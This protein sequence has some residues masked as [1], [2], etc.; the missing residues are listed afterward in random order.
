MVRLIAF[1]ILVGLL[2]AGAVWLA[3][4]PGDVTVEW[5]GWRV[6]TTVPVLLLALALL[7]AVFAAIRAAVLALL[8]VPGFFGRKRRD[9]RQRKGMDALAEGLAAVIAEDVYRARKKAAEAES[10]L[11]LPQVARLL[12]ARA[13]LLGDDP[14]VARDLNREL[15][16]NRGTEMA[17]LRGLMDEALSE[18]RFEEAAGY[19]AR[20]FDRNP[21]AAWAGRAL[22]EAQVKGRQW[23]AA[24][25]T[26][27]TARK[28][29]VFP[30]AEA[31]RLRATIFCARHDEAAAAG[32]KYEATRF[33][34]KAVDAEPAF[35]P[36]Q[37]RLARSLAAEGSTRK[38]ADLIEQAWRRSPNPE[39]ARAYMDL[40]RDEDVLKRVTRAERLAETNPEHLE[41]RLL[42]AQASLE[43]ELW[44]QARA[45]LKPAVDGGVRDARLAALMARLEEA[46]RG[47]LPEAV[48]W[49]RQAAEAAGLEPQPWRCTACGTATSEWTPTCGA[50]GS[51]GRVAWGGGRALVT[52]HAPDAV[53]APPTRPGAPATGS[54]GERAATEGAAASPRAAAGAA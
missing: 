1:L 46:E 32:Q 21:R 2:V 50:C 13:A 39:L 19:A 6:D 53:P 4:R 47:N 34:R 17:G 37:I 24:L 29:G 38:A 18:G 44:G 15:L 52:L 8:G 22:F 9:R 28:N 36:A 42:V 3:E 16:A 48:R 23:D 12:L 27:T 10:Q 31:D 11:G 20:A 30:V 33:A 25:A 45:R 49:W 54:A 5:L 26:L 14:Q 35:L 40:W 7:V 41:S 51:F 43:A